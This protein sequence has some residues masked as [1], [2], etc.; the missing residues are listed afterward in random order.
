M[1]DRTVPP[2]QAKESGFEEQE[3]EGSGKARSMSRN[4]LD[5]ELAP[6]LYH[7]A[8][9]ISTGSTLLIGQPRIQRGWVAKRS[10][11]SRSVEEKIDR[12][13]EEGNGFSHVRSWPAGKVYCASPRSERFLPVYVKIVAFRFDLLHTI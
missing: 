6:H 9:Y 10:S 1:Y 11:K 13:T 4:L 7:I 8:G 3:G 2:L 5:L 12:R